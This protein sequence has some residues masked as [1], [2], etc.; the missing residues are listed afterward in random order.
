M[1]SADEISVEVVYAL[2]EQAC[3]VPLKVKPGTTIRQAIE[4]SGLLQKFPEIDLD[5]NQ[6]GIYSRLKEP[7]TVLR[8][9]DRVEIYRGLRV[10]PKEARRRR[11]ARKNSKK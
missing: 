5:R 4:L 10:D 3:I 11:A 9:G 2:P 7:G 1:A 6:T 8:D